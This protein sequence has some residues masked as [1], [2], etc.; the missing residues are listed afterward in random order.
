MLKPLLSLLGYL[1]L[2]AVLAQEEGLYAPAPPAEA[3]FVRVLNADTATAGEVAPTLGET[4]YERL[5]YGSVSPYRVVL[6]GTSEFR[7]G[8][9]TASLEFEAGRF[10]TVTLTEE[11]T[12]SADPGLENRAQTL[13]LVY[14]AS[15]TPVNLKTADGSTD[16]IPDVPPG[17]VGS[18]EVNPIS[19]ELIAAKPGDKT[20]LA[21][22]SLA[23][24]Q[25]GTYSIFLLPIEGGKLSA[26]A[27]QNKTERYTGK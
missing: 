2:G 10:Y 6:Q 1:A 21:R 20:P 19:V 12:L 15:D 4:T 13:L 26:L 5:P 8:S 17:K 11:A 16:V 18:I 25:G 22:T 9:V 7:A 24:T 27:A 14:N 23:M 3:A